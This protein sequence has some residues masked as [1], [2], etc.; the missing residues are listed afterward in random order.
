MNRRLSPI[1][2]KLLLY[3]THYCTASIQEFEGFFM[4]IYNL[5]Q[6]KHLY[7]LDKD[8]CNDDVTILRVECKQANWYTSLSQASH[9]LQDRFPTR[10][11][12]SGTRDE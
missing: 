10:S 3:N 11:A 12:L 1:G 4:Y 6:P 8:D 9:T 2:N 7:Q 5:T